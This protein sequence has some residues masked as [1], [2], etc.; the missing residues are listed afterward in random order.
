MSMELASYLTDI[1]VP[2]RILLMCLSIFFLAASS[3]IGDHDKKA[4]R[5]A[6]ILFLIVGILGIFLPS[7]NTILLMAGNKDKPVFERSIYE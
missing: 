1:L 2:I 6:F 5:C 4:S 3:M 7:E